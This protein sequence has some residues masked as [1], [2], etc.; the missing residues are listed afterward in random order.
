MSL[1]PS[2]DLARQLRDTLADEVARSKETRACLKGADVKALLEFATRRELFHQRSTRLSDTLGQSLLGVAQS[3]GLADVSMPELEARFPDE[4]K[5]LGGLFAEIR[6]LSAALKELDELNH[7]LAQ[8]ALAFV[9]AYVSFL[10]PR[11]AAYNRLGRVAAP[12]EPLTV[13]E[14]A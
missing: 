13:S 5:A 9:R 8:R 11:P 2:I 4:A 6:A 14:H 1:A 12:A 7:S 10:T 3:L